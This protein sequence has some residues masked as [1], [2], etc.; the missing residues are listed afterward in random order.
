[1]QQ[2]SWLSGGG[3]VP[4]RRLGDV[5]TMRS[6]QC[7]AVLVVVLCMASLAFDRI[8]TEYQLL[9]TTAR[10]EQVGYAAESRSYINEDRSGTSWNVPLKD[11]LDVQISFRFHSPDD[12]PYPTKFL[13]VHGNTCPLG[14]LPPSLSGR[15]VL[16]FTTT[17]STGDLNI[18]FVGDSIAQQFAQGFYSSA[19]EDEKVGGHVIARAFYNDGHVLSIDGRYFSKSG[20]HVCSSIVAPTRGGGS[21]SYFRVLELMSNK[22]EVRSNVN[23][24]REKT[25]SRQEA[26]RLANYTY[27][28][29]ATSTENKLV[30]KETNKNNGSTTWMQSEPPDAKN[31]TSVNINGVDVAVLRPQHGWM[32]LDEITRDRLIEQVELMHEVFGARVVVISTLPLNNNV[33]TKD[34]WER[35]I[36]INGFIRDIVHDWTPRSEDAVQWI[37]V[38]EFANLTNQM[39]WHNAIHIGYNTSLPDFSFPG[40][41]SAGSDIFL[42]RHK[43]L[44]EI[45]F[46]PSIPMVCAHHIDQPFT[47][48]DEPAGPCLF[49]RISRDGMHWCVESL[50]P[51]YSASIACLTGCVYNGNI[52]NG[53]KKITFDRST[54]LKLRQCE[55]ECNERLM[56]VSPVNPE[57]ISSM[58][59]S[60]YSRIT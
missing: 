15:S 31:R 43:A 37:L 29:P 26:K 24:K 5:A 49:N 16:N 48:K 57:W 60:L 50:G 19:L 55:Q 6:L 27:V 36:Q 21:A 10:T 8:E 17:I 41:E 12:V 32:K 33:I 28:Y 13:S 58:E 30:K 34:D 59:L 42:H 7:F 2:K 1:M 44:K 51:R 9:R 54:S 45:R 46:E 35:V 47:T 18:M 22:T 14:T 38:Q 52:Y 20:L 23:C 40:W 25:W 3:L 11:T 4:R 39:L 53:N 56:T